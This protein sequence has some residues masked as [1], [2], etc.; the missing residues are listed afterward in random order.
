[1]APNYYGL[2]IGLELELQSQAVGKACGISGSSI[3]F[4]SMYS[5]PLWR[6]LECTL[7]SDVRYDEFKNESGEVII[8]N[9]VGSPVAE[10]VLWKYK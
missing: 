1:M 6:K 8:P 5:Q 3:L 7:L 2:G 10:L 4:T 9:V